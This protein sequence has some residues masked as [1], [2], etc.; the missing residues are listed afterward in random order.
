MDILELHN[1]GSEFNDRETK[2]LRTIR[3]FILPIRAGYSE[4]KSKM[5]CSYAIQVSTHVTLFSQTLASIC[6]IENIGELNQHHL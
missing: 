4:E 3:L 6:R 5:T 2:E 1:A